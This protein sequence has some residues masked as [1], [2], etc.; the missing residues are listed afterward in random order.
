ME[1]QLTGEKIQPFGGDVDEV[2]L[3]GA[4]VAAVGFGGELLHCTTWRPP[5]PG[6]HHCNIKINITTYMLQKKRT[7]GIALN[8]A[9]RLLE[10]DMPCIHKQQMLI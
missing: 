6:L 3:G 5:A 1:Y 8:G 4:E 7:T 2:L 9:C 10:L